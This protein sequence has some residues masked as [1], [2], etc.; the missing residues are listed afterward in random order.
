MG[1]HIVSVHIEVTGTLELRTLSRSTSTQSQFLHKRGNNLY[2][3]F[4]V[5]PTNEKQ[6]TNFMHIYQPVTH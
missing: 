5:Q 6:L 3:Y 2:M 4:E 1:I